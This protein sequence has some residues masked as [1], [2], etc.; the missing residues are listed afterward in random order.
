MRGG[1]HELALAAGRAH[2]LAH[3]FTGPPHVVGVRRVGAD[4]R[5]AEPVGELVEP[6][7]MEALAH[8]TG[9]CTGPAACLPPVQAIGAGRAD[10]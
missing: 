8:P 2:E 3:P 7:G 10:V 5:D 6:G 1:G 4:A 9:E